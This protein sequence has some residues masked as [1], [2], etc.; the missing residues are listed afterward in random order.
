LTGRRCPG[1]GLRVCPVPVGVRSRLQ[2]LMGVAQGVIDV[3]IVIG[4]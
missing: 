1:P 3:S 4:S 2:Y